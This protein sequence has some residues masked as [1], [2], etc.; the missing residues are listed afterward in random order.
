MDVHARKATVMGLGRF[1]GG[2]AAARWLARAGA[3]VTVTDLADEHALADSLAELHAEPIAAYRL[4]RHDEADF[5][6]PGLV[7]V[8]PAVKPGNRFL[9]IARQ[10][11]ARLVTEIELLLERFPG[12][13]IGVTGSNGKSTTAAMTAAILRA[14]GWRAWLGGNLGGSLLD[15]L[16]EMTPDDWAVLE[17]SSFQLHHCSADAR[18]PDVAVVTGCTPNHLDWHGSFAEYVAAKQRMLAGPT[19]ESQGEGDRHHL[20]GAPRG[21]FPGKWCQPP[22]P[23]LAVLNTADPEVATWAH[24]VRGELLPLVADETVPELPVPGAHNRLNA[25]LASTAALGIGCPREAV[26]EGLRPYSTLPGRLEMVAVIGGR[27]LYNDTTATT[28]E[29]TVAALEALGGRTWL[30]AGGGDKG[31]DFS[32][33]GEAVVRLARG[34][35]F[36]GKVRQRLR[37]EVLGRDA[38]F[39]CAAPESLPEAFHW[40]WERSRPED[41]IVLSPGC[42]SHDQYRDFRER[43]RHFLDL[44]RA[45]ADP[46]SR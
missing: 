23:R 17:I 22:F 25:R 21:P 16:G 26:R 1:G 43:G 12:R 45:L 35:A 32:A 27:R 34:A 40:C 4:G 33:L 7:V 42:S 37:S 36:Y 15:R 29:S 31:C 20:C 3:E 38:H 24:V 6:H 19:G 2:V 11:G 44:V 39:P 5:R 30:L 46:R 10:A 28:P 13:A 41:R 9:Q 14:A 8:N 18:M